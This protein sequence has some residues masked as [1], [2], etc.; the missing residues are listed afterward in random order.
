MNSIKSNEPNFIRILGYTDKGLSYLKQIKKDV[1]IYTN[2]KNNQN[3][4]LDITIKISK[5]LDLIYN[6]DLL[7]LEQSKPVYVKGSEN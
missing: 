1:N 5:I 7:K 3:E 6:Q 2:I 4:I